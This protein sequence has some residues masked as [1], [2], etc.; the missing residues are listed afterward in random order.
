[1]SKL[2]YVEIVERRSK[3]RIAGQEHYAV[4][5]KTPDGR[6]VD[7]LLTPMEFFEA[8]ERRQIIGHDMIPPVMAA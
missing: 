8:S 4:R 1:M 5:V 6:H 7:L 3:T 2:G